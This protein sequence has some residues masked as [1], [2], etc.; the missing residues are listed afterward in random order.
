VW[1]H[2]FAFQSVVSVASFLGRFLY[3]SLRSRCERYC[4]YLCSS[5]ILY[6]I[7][8]L[9]VDAVNCGAWPCCLVCLECC[10]APCQGV[11][12]SLAVFFITA[13]SIV[14]LEALGQC[15]PP[16]RHVLPVPPSGESVWIISCKSVW[17]F[18]HK[19]ANR[20]TNNDDYISSLVEVKIWRR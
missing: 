10:S 15:I 4:V 9:Y 6:R 12:H 2:K 1:Q 7:A 20:Q 18:L 17:K 14:E 5:W 13:E 3:A 8:A 16:P 11:F 19:V